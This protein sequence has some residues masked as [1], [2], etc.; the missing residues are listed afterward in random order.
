MPSTMLAIEIKRKTCSKDYFP[1]PLRVEFI[2]DVKPSSLGFLEK[3]Q[4][5]SQKKN[6]RLFF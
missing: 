6:R 1:S 4:Y 5:F 3:W 2:K